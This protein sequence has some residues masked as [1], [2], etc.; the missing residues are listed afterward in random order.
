ME[1]KLRKSLIPVLAALMLMML[2]CER[3]PRAQQTLAQD[4]LL[5]ERDGY[6]LYALADMPQGKERF[7]DGD[8]LY[9]GLLLYV[10]PGHPLDT[11][12]TRQQARNV[13]RMV[14]LY[15][16]AAETVTLSEP[17]IYA[18]CALA[19]DNPLLSTWITAGMRSP[20]EQRLL[21][22][23][24]FE[25]YRATMPLA[26]AMSRAIAD[27]PDGGCSEH[28]LAECFDVQLG[29]QLD[30]SQA[31]PLLRTEDGRWLAENAWR[32]GVIRRYPPDKAEC[33]G[34]DAERLHFRYVGRV[35]AAAM[36][37][38]DYCLEAYLQALHRYG[39]LRLDGP[40]GETCYILCAQMMQNGA[41]FVL[42][43]GY[44]AAPS[45]DNLGYAVCA[46][47]AESGL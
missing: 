45:A 38:A 40:Q 34:R 46:L 14:G 8:A 36:H 15:V 27:V 12:R 28:Q 30:W 44:E 26:Q 18:L 7:F 11:Q 31:D 10:S 35:H 39:A 22:S 13:R 33:A 42:P 32:Y 3:S 6:A 20:E 1:A 43:D 47:T 5:G 41:A 2:F 19:A 25:S 29:G 37:A 17:A 16:P 9:Q 4:V 24:A 21:Q 23:Q